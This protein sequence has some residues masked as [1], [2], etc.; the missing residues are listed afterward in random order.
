MIDGRSEMIVIGCLCI[1]SLDFLFA[2]TQTLAL[3]F[4]Y[5]QTKNT[6][7]YTV[8]GHKRVVDRLRLLSSVSFLF[9][10]L[11]SAQE[12]FNKGDNSSSFNHIVPV[13]TRPKNL[14]IPSISRV[15]L[16]M[17][18]KKTPQKT[19]RKQNKNKKIIKTT[20]VNIVY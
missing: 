16:K 3:F 14:V 9:D 10:C 11:A 7:T 5:E 12:R 17:W 20:K 8:S 13:S 18:P 4:S 6:E 1:N 19:P 2:I 15:F